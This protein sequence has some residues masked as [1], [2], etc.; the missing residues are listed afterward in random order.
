MS[1]SDYMTFSDFFVIQ[2][3]E[4]VA[5]LVGVYFILIYELKK[6]K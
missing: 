3:I 6:R 5:I 4:A 2:I 1:M